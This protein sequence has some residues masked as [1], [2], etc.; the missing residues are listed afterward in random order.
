MKTIG[1]ILFIAILLGLAVYRNQKEKR[2][3]IITGFR[4]NL[5]T[6]KIK[7]RH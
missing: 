5:I 3:N 1:I 4:G 7:W 6:G 2:K